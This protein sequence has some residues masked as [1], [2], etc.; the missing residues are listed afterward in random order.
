MDRE[1]T[2]RSLASET[3]AK[4]RNCGRQAQVSVELSSRAA[5]TGA[6]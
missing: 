1:R 3:R 5:G 6:A 4:V 2:L